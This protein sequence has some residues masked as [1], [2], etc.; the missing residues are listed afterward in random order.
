MQTRPPHSSPTLSWFK[1]EA[2]ARA[3]DP[4]KAEGSSMLILLQCSES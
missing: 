1:W 3:G 4:G 2:A